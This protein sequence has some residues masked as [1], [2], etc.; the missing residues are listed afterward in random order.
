[1]RVIEVLPRIALVFCRPSGAKIRH[2]VLKVNDKDGRV[3][4]KPVKCGAVA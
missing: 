2:T 4:E 1:M 3:G